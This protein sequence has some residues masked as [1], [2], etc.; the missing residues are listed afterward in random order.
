MFI[1]DDVFTSRLS[2]SGLQGCFG[3]KPDLLTLG[4]WL[5]GGFAFGAFGGRADVMAVYDPRSA[6]PLAHSGTFNNNTMAMSVGHAGLSKIWTAEVGIAF[7][8]EGDRLRQR[9]QE[10]TRGTK[11]S[12]TG[13]GALL[14]VHFSDS[15]LQDIRS[16]FDVEERWDLKDLFWFE[17]LKHGFWLTKRGSISLV[18]G[19]PTEELDRFVGCVSDFL[20]TYKEIVRI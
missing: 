7:N 20:Q 6:T 17:M 12:F 2:P 19:T 15:G 11:C 18:L 10:V 4:K 5:G 14:A 9:L 3:L 8:S 1:L 13:M 16:V